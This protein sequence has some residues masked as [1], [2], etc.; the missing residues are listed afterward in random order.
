[1]TTYRK[2]Y[3][4]FSMNPLLDL[5]N[6]IQWHVIHPRATCHIA[7]CCHEANSKNPLLDPKIQD[8]SDPPSLKSTWR[9]FFCWA[10]SDL[11]KILQTGANA[12]DVDCGDMVEIETRCRIPIWRPFG[13]IQW[14]V[15]PELPA[16]LQG[17][18]SWRIQC[19]DPRATCHIA[20]CC[21][22]ANSVACHPRATYLIVGC[23]H[24]TVTIPEPHATLQGAVT[25]RNQCHN[26]YLPPYFILFF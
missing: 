25:W 17:A 12:T 23:W 8:G 4:G 3:V 22:R 26:R 14:R 2:S 19:H 20:C 11:D 15:I 7:G 5:S 16:T 9:H 18:A 6:G 24:F 10:W 21:H 1:L 13:R